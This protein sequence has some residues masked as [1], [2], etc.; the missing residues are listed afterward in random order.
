MAGPGWSR[1]S[2]QEV[3][4]TRPSGLSEPLRTRGNVTRT[5]IR[6]FVFSQ[7]PRVRLAQN[8]GPASGPLQARHPVCARAS[9]Q[10]P[11]TA[12]TGT[13]SSKGLASRSRQTFAFSPSLELSGSLGWVSKEREHGPHLV[14]P[15]PPHHPQEPR[16]LP[17]AS[18]QHSAQGPPAFL[19]TASNSSPCVSTSPLMS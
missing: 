1:A 19:E 16:D 5:Q 3:P 13:A 6:T 14:S 7:M 15:R 10:G 17:H 8:L 11:A 2:R 18:H 4:M 9:G 12:L